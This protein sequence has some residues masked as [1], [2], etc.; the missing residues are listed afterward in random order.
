MASEDRSD[1]S[2]KA[3]RAASEDFRQLLASGEA[4]GVSRAI[5]A[6]FASAR[7]CL[8]RLLIR[9]GATPDRLTV[10]G[11][12]MTIGAGYC[13]A[14]GASQQ[15]PYFSTGAGP[16]GWWPL[17][18]AGFLILASAFDMLDGA[19]ARLGNMSSR[20]G[21]I[22]DSVVDRFSDIAI[23]LGCAL[24]FAWHGNLTYQLLAMLALCNAVLISYVKARAENIVPDCSAGYWLRGERVAA[25]LIACLCG[26]VPA[27]LWQQATLP[28]LTVWRRLTYAQQAATALAT[29]RPAPPRGPVSGWRGCFSFGGI[30]ADRSP[31]TSSPA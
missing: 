5:G 30:R 21:A 6:G 10:T 14:R 1:T 27:V 12:V 7:D 9:V 18:A 15:L 13:L 20:F 28:V 26:H 31:T 23:F 17:W 3:A 29:G 8:A 25:M 4:S 16:V 22:L 24:H 2:T 11:F 19:V